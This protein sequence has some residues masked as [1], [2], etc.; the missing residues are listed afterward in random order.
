DHTGFVGN[1]L[2]PDNDTIFG[3]TRSTANN[4]TRRAQTTAV[5]VFASDRVWFTPQISVLGGLRWSR[6]QTDYQQFGPGFPQTTLNPD[7][8]FVDPR[9]ALIW[10]PT[11][12]QTFYFSYA[13]ST[14]APGSNFATQPG[15]ATT[16]ANGSLDP[17]RNTIYELGTHVNVLDSRLGLTAAVYQIEKNN[18][19]ETDPISGTTFSSGDRQRI[20]GVDLGVT[21]RV[22]DAWTINAHYSY[23]DSDTTRSLTPANVGRAVALVPRH[24]ASLWTTYDINR[25]QPWNLTLGGGVTWNSSIWLNPAN[26][27]RVP[28]LFSLDALISHKINDHLTVSMNAYNLTDHRNYTQLQNNRA[29]LGAGRTVLVSLAASF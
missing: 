4:A 26:T 2:A 6:F 14:F 13:Q 15:Q 24:S 5:G 20:R 3:Y 7:N 29:V 10:E 8:S 21:G 17:E 9:A 12:N 27:A 28:E 11:P 25:D 1:L 22:T 18:A 16:A 23:L 19:T